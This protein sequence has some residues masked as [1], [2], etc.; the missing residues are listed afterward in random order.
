LEAIE[1]IRGSARMENSKHGKYIK[2]SKINPKK[3]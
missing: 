1:D 2:D 3:H